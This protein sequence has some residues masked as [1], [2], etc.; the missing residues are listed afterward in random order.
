MK[1]SILLIKNWQSRKRK[2]KKPDY[3]GE[4]TM[5]QFSKGEAVALKADDLGLDLTAG[6]LGGIWALYAINPSS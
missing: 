2:P 6:I 1:R 5:F 3:K 4:A